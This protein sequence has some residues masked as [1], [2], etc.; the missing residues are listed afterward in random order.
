LTMVGKRREN[1]AFSKLE[2][3]WKHL[4]PVNNHHVEIQT[5]QKMTVKE[6]QLKN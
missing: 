5:I 3:S 6:K 2:Q 1:I 4:K